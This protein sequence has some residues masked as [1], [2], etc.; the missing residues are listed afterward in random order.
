MGE[1]AGAQRS[2]AWLKIAWQLSATVM[3][4]ASEPLANALAMCR[5]PFPEKLE[6]GIT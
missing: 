3:V 5:L 4:M 2:C 1:G 6:E